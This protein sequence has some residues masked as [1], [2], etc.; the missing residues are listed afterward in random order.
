VSWK[1]SV[2]KRND[3]HELRRKELTGSQVL[4]SVAA[5][6]LGSWR[7]IKGHDVFCC[8]HHWSVVRLDVM[9]SG[10]KRLTE[11]LLRVAIGMVLGSID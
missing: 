9:F 4:L 6:P 2:S 1:E 10:D 11:S 7:Q 5:V 8:S 3:C